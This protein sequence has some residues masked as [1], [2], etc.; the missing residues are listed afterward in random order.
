MKT[1]VLSLLLAVVMVL[2][3]VPVLG[4]ALTQ[5]AQA[6]EKLYG[7]TVYYSAPAIGKTAGSMTR[8]CSSSNFDISAIWYKVNPI[9]LKKDGYLMKEAVFGEGFYGVDIT[10]TPKEGFFFENGFQMKVGNIYKTANGPTINVDVENQKITVT[11]Q[12][13]LTSTIAL[14]KLSTGQT[15]LA[16]NTPDKAAPYVLDANGNAVYNDADAAPT[17]ILEKNNCYWYEGASVESPSPMK[18]TDT[19]QKGKSYTYRFRIKPREGFSFGESVKFQCATSDNVMIKTY[20]LSSLNT[21]I[22]DFTYYPIGMEV[23]KTAYFSNVQ[24]PVIG[25][26]VNATADSANGD[27]E[28]LDVEWLEEFDIDHFAPLPEGAKFEKG[29]YY[30]L[31]ITFKSKAGYVFAEHF[32]YDLKDA[33]GADVDSFGA[34]GPHVYGSGNYRFEIHIAPIEKAPDIPIKTAYFSN[35]QQ[36]VIGQTIKATA[37]SAK[38]DL[39]ILDVEWMEELELDHYAA[40]PDGAKFEKDKY[41]LLRILFKAKAGYVF[42][43]HFNYDLKDANG[44]D[45]D[46]FGADGPTPYGGNYLFEIHIG[47]VEKA[48]DVTINTAYFSNVQQPVIG[49]PVNATA[50][51]AKGDL[52]I[53]DVEWMEE[54]E[55]DHYAALPDGAKFEK[56]KYYVLRILFKAKA[57]YVFAA[58]FNYDLKDANG[59][60]VDSFGADGPTPYGGNYLFEIHIGPVEKA[61]EPAFTLG[62]VD[63]D[64]EIK[65]GDA[66]LALRR[67][68]D[69]ETYKPESREFKACDINLDGSVKTGDARMILRKAIGFK[70][71]DWGVKK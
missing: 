53:L 52:E 15:P 64:G 43:A 19:F 54:I 56:D 51:S 27:L 20:Y 45:V 66:R 63:G 57:G 36:P 5:Q 70:D 69:L 59:A 39:E 26:T 41:Y 18:K 22:V 38:G 12:F 28:I 47:P 7:A 8:T 17:V 35:V 48:P 24:Q 6:A 40:L 1:R 60:D 3:A 55:L 68:I 13:S 58:H 42:A 9:T 2:S 67:A 46:S 44:A 29:K 61:P 65:T 62:D 23:I 31:S 50:D 71:A 33:N 32:N 14:L 30:M 37:D 10:L 34:N 16:G 4:G 49:E 11:E 21:F 25:Q